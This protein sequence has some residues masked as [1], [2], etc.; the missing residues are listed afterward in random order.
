MNKNLN[1]H[2]ILIMTLIV[3]FAYS[4]TDLVGQL[5]TWG[6]VSTQNSSYHKS[7]GIRYVP[8]LYFQIP[9]IS[10][11]LDIEISFNL[12]TSSDGK[13]ISSIAD[14]LNAKFYRAWLR[15]S[16]THTDLR[17]GLQRINFGPA[18]LLRSLRWFDQL[19]PRDP[20]QFTTGV[21][22]LRYK[23][24]FPNNS[25]LWFLVMISIAKPES[26][27]FISS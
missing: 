9:A 25:N 27:C 26:F 24:D 21:W 22:G 15:H 19:D 14:N 11:R 23:Y 3:S 4:N 8:E 18:R 1:I 5:S 13:S 20:L 17:F 6:R 12:Y 7:F 2:P 16:T 10:D